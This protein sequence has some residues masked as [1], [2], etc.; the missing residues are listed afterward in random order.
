MTF[1][2]AA[3]HQIEI[4]DAD[5][6]LEDGTDDRDDEDSSQ[7]A[8]VYDELG[9]VETSGQIQPRQRVV[10]SDGTNSHVMHRVYIAA[11]NSYY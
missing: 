10:L 1:T 3:N 11:S 5:S 2:F 9:Q 4:T 8:V 6:R 7:T